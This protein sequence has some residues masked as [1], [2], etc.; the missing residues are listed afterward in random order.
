MPSI[1]KEKQS[2]TS[3][4]FQTQ[5]QV[6]PPPPP[7]Q[8]MESTYKAAH[9]LNSQP[10]H[11]GKLLTL[12]DIFQLILGPSVVSCCFRQAVPCQKGAYAESAQPGPMRCQGIFLTFFNMQGARKP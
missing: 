5:R 8:S 11:G 1:V 4:G 7:K 12:A 6:F 10:P 3:H 2:S 9:I